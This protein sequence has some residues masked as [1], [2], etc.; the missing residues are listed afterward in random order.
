MVLRKAV[1]D[2]TISF[3]HTGLA[4]WLSARWEENQGPR[5]LEWTALHSTH[6]PNPVPT[7]WMT[8][9]SSPH[10][11]FK[12]LCPQT[13]LVLA[14]PFLPMHLAKNRKP[15]LR[16]GFGNASSFPPPSPPNSHAFSTVIHSGISDQS[17]SAGYKT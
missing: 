11:S 6:P 16:A 7:S 13:A 4:T 14:F 10:A 12:V 17:A 15:V 5:G 2:D 3:L 1:R 8:L 9:E